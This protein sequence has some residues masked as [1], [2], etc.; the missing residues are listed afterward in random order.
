MPKSYDSKFNQLHPLSLRRRTEFR[1]PTPRSH[2]SSTSI[3]LR[4]AK[5]RSPQAAVIPNFHLPMHSLEVKNSLKKLR[6][7]KSPR[8]GGNRF[9]KRIG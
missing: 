1:F 6:K 4:N 3:L 5:W 7:E 8:K 2:S 9:L